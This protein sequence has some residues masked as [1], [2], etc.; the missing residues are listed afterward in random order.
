MGP[1]FMESI[2]QHH[3]FL[4]CHFSIDLN[5]VVVV[6]GRLVGQVYHLLP[7]SLSLPFSFPHWQI[8]PQFQTWQKFSCALRRLNLANSLKVHMVLSVDIL[9]GVCVSK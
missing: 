5:L 9:M 6:G 2:T 1:D 3:L 7:H 4:L 8:I